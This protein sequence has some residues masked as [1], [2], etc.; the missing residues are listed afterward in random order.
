MKTFAKL[1]ILAAIGLVVASL[2]WVPSAAASVPAPILVSTSDA[3]IQGN[4]FSH[5]PSA[6]ADGTKVAFFSNATNLDPGDTD[7]IVDVYVK[8]LSTG[9]ITLAST[10]DSG[11]K[12]NGDSSDFFRGVS[13]SADGTTVAF[14]SQATNLDPA[15]TDT[16]SDVY[17]KDLSTGDITLA[18]TSD[19]GIKGDDDSYNPSISADGTKVAFQSSAGD[20]DLSGRGG[21][22]VKDLSTGDITL[23]SSSDSGIAGDA[24]SVAPS[25]SADGNHVAFGSNSTNLDPGDTDNIFDVYVKDLV[26]GDVTLAS[27]TLSGVKG[28]DDSASFLFHAVSLSTDG[29]TV[30]FESIAE[31]LDPADNDCAGVV[32][33]T[34]T[35]DVYVKNLSTGD[36]TLASTSESGTKGNRTSIEVSISSDG[37]KVAFPSASTNLDPADTDTQ[38]DV[39][40][41][42]LSTGDVTLASGG[43]WEGADPSLSADGTSV[44]FSSPSPPGSLGP[45][46]IYKADLVEAAPGEC[47]ISGTDGDDELKG[48]P[49]SDVICGLGGNDNIKGLAGNDIVRGGTGVDV[50]AGGAGSDLVQGEGGDDTVRTDDGLGGNDTADGGSGT[51]KC[52][53]DPGDAKISCP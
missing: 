44:A 40:V 32:R 31:N 51:D 18:S 1:S 16:E 2:T 19:S 35:P 20:L 46:N 23:A 4:G 34:G 37:L 49:L 26:T 17:V 33:C 48:T 10:N 45:S 52:K 28:N 36:L 22:F 13:L 12:G 9:D 39:F 21:V 29:T 30:A 5:M 3:G 27:T 38:G 43:N 47:T 7:T 41:R 14:E 25:L 53:V 50:L 15:D 24:A 8:D 42:D 11:I 6:S